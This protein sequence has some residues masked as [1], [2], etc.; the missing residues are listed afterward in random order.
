MPTEPRHLVAVASTSVVLHVPLTSLR[1]ER[2]RRSHREQHRPLSQRGERAPHLEPG[3][4]K[5][6][7]LARFTVNETLERLDTE[8]E[9]SHGKGALMS[10]ASLAKTQELLR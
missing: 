9:L 3:S 7:A 2:F 6:L 4:G 10:E 5:D 1:K 8:A